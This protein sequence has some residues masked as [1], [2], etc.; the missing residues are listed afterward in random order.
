MKEFLKGLGLTLAILVGVSAVT[1]L[2]CSVLYVAVPSF[3]T[4]IDRVMGWNEFAETE[5]ETNDDTTD[6]E[7]P[8]VITPKEDE[9]VEATSFVFENDNIKITVG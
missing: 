9:N 2:T 1:A 7:N 8:D 4:E 6:D 5:D 3:A